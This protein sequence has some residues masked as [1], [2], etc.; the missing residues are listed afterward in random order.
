MLEVFTYKLADTNKEQGEKLDE[1]TT[2]SDQRADDLKTFLKSEVGRIDTNCDDI[3][4]NLREAQNNAKA[5][6]DRLSKD[7]DLLEKTS[8]QSNANKENL[9]SK[10]SELEDTIGQGLNDQDSTF[11]QRMKVLK[12][13][14]QRWISD[15]QDDVSLRMKQRD[16][17][18]V[19]LLPEKEQ[20]DY[21]RA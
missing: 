8:K 21:L 20:L 9:D 16:G 5:M 15:M 4:S 2:L 12:D 10:V 3:K 14:T 13:D 18:G 17:R 19:V 7:E 11:Q 1:L 6:S